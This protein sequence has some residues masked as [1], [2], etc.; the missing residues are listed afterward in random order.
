MYL[1]LPKVIYKVCI[2]TYLF[3]RLNNLY[4][5]IRTQVDSKK[6]EIES[7]SISMY[8]YWQSGVSVRIDYRRRVSICSIETPLSG[9]PAI[10]YPAD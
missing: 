7:K 2:Y 8:L 5:F 9:R 6:P 1:Y 3:K 10:D 4:V